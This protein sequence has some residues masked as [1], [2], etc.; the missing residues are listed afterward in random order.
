MPKRF[1]AGAIIQSLRSQHIESVLIMT[2]A[3]RL[4]P[5]RRRRAFRIA[6]SLSALLA[7]TSAPVMAEGNDKS[8]EEG[9]KTL[10]KG[11][12]NLLKGMGQ[13]I[14]KVIDPKDE[15]KKEPDKKETKQAD[16]TKPAEN[17]KP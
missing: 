13:E 3:N 7:I 6:I 9:A 16:D 10:E 17:K 4:Y 8:V 5:V 2:N 12:G 11:F 15:P 14:G 1:N